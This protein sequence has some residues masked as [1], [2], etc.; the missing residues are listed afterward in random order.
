[1]QVVIHHCHHQRTQL[2]SSM[3]MGTPSLALQLE[4]IPRSCYA[5]TTAFV[6]IGLMVL[7]QGEDLIVMAATTYH[8]EA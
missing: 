8:K 4:Q 6:K 3:A 5:N 2:I 7:L 1:M